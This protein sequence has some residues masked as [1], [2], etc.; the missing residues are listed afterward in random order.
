MLEVLCQHIPMLH[1]PYIVC[2]NFTEIIR[3]NV[4]GN[5]EHAGTNLHFNI[6]FVSAVA[7]PSGLQIWPFYTQDSQ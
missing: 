2:K 6:K 7:P 3:N 5:K 4:H 1:R